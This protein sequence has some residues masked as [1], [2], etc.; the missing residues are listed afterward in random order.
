MINWKRSALL[1]AGFCA[2]HTAA[3]QQAPGPQHA[4]IRTT[5][6]VE[7]DPQGKVVRVE[8]DASLTE[9]FRQL[10]STRI[11]GWQF[12]APT[13][14][15]QPVHANTRLDLRLQPAPTTAG[16]YGLRVVSAGIAP[17]VAN[18]GISLPRFTGKPPAGTTQLVYAVSIDP[19]GR[20]ADVELALPAKRSRLA[21]S[22]DETTRHAIEQAPPFARTADGAPIACRVVFSMMYVFDGTPAPDADR[23]IHDVAQTLPDLCPNP[24]LRTEVAGT[25]L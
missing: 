19:D 24:L 10:L 20:V 16:G 18:G 22:L 17:L 1:A 14:R 9:V 13:F 5:V 21:R 2:A 15:G 3:A 4:E 7:I 8:P 23:A 25:V 12:D 6:A 11:A